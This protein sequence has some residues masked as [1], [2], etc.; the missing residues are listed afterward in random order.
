MTLV[1]RSAVMA[2]GLIL[3][4]APLT[5]AVSAADKVKLTVLVAPAN[6]T[7]YAAAVVAY[8]KS[9]PGITIE[10]DYAGSKI[11]VAQIQQ[12]AAAD[13]VLIN[14]SSATGELA[15]FLDTPTTVF[16]NHTAIAVAKGAA[17]KIHDAKDLAKPGVRIGA[18]TP[19]SVPASYEGDTVEKLAKAYGKDFTAKYN[20]NVTATKTDTPKLTAMLAD[21]LIDAAIVFQADIDTSKVSGIALPADQQVVIPYA[22]ATVKN[23]QHAAAA[24][25]FATWLAGDEA[26]AIY[27]SF[28]HDAK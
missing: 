21:N 2:M 27:K 6:K 28:H 25:E 9:H 8:E 19:G 15:S 12:G 1:H 5:Q 26:T 22:V 10:T 18:G 14:T 23:S 4:G 3:F 11:I 16:K 24:K 17:G 20:A 7:A 13:V